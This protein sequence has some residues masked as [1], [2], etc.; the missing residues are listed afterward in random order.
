LEIL[1]FAEGGKP[2]NPEKLEKNSQ[3]NA[4]TNDKLNPRMARGQLQT[5]AP[6]LG[7]ERFHHCAILA[8]LYITWDQG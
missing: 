6:L 2:E 5:Q 8:L 7:V 4:R 3:S 1:G